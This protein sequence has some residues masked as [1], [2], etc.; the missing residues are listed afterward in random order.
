MV[1]PGATVMLDV[2]MITRLPWSGLAF[3][4]A[5]AGT[6]VGAGAVTEIVE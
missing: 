6:T 5:K 1:M 4:I 3:A 2:T